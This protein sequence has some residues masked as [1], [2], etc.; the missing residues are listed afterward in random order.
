MRNS[1]SAGKGKDWG[2]KT[3]G[4]IHAGQNNLFRINEKGKHFA[5]LPFLFGRSPRRRVGPQSEVFL[6]ESLSLAG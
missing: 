3:G 4:V 2:R 6:K 1:I 5:V